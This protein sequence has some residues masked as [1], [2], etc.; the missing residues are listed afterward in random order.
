MTE[1]PIRIEKIKTKDLYVY[2]R[3]VYEA[4]ERK[5]F[6]PVSKTRALAHSKNPCADVNDIGLIVAYKGDQCVGYLGLMPGLLKTGGQTSKIYWISTWFVPPE[7]R[8]T[9]IGLSLILSAFSLKYDLVVCNMSEQA[10]GVYRG[11][12]FQELGPLNYFVINVGSLNF[13]NL[14][15]RVIRKIFFKIGVKFEVPDA[16]IGLSD[17][18]YF[19][20][21]RIIYGILLYMH[22]KCGDDIDYEVVSEVHKCNRRLQHNSTASEFYRNSDVINWMLQNKWTQDLDKVEFADLN[23]YFTEIGKCFQYI[24]LAVY[25]SIGR[26]YKGFLVISFSVH[27][28]DAVLKI[29]DYQ[30]LNNEDQK[31]IVFLA[32]KYA[33][34][35]GANSIEFPEDLLNSS[36]VRNGLLS[37]VLLRQK[38]RVYLCHPKNGHSALAS[39]MHDMRLNYCD[40]DTP[41]T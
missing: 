19:P 28:F 37:R 24:T 29:L 16:V 15:L 30:F 4:T 40:G 10:E 7:H 33:S 21:K 38:K 11:L 26:E 13:F 36:C 8:K 12:R 1:P 25:S 22:R 27:K 32:L 23:Y 14:A 17:L 2:S 5:G 41:F 35:Y 18:V 3:R 39:S 6:I 34:I 20:L 9:S 31:N